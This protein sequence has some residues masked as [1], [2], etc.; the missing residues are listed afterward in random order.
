MV[1]QRG[2]LFKSNPLWLHLVKVKLK[3][4]EELLQSQTWTGVESN[5]DAA[6]C[7]FSY[8]AKGWSKSRLLKA[9]RT[10]KEYVRV[11]YLG[12]QQIV[13]VYQYACYI[14]SYDVEAAGLH[15]LYKQRSTSETWIEQ[16]KGHTMAGSTL[17]Y[18]FWANDILWQLSVLAYN[19]SVMMRQKNMRTNTGVYG[20][21]MP[22]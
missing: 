17:T 10:V 22:P 14:S 5:Q 19:I 12:Q 11:S 2:G 16:V 20:R 13:P 4:L 1:N 8:T 21:N 9:I 6:I 3:N 18:D 15:E 7:E